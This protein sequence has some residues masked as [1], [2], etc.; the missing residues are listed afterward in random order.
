MIVGFLGDAILGTGAIGA[1]VL[2]IEQALGSIG[3][4]II[5]AMAL[6]TAIYR[7]RYWRD[8]SRRE[9]GE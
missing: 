9:R 1:Y 7:L 5:F 2:R 4:A 6:V 8:K 3:A